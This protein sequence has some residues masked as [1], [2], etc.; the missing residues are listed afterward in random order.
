MKL[1]PQLI[2]GD[3]SAG[4]I[5]GVDSIIVPKN[6]VERAVNLVFDEVYGSA[7]VRKGSTA[8]GSQIENAN[9]DGLFN[10]IDSNNVNNKLLA[11]INGTTYYYDSGSWLPS[12]INDTAGLKT[13]FVTF[14]NEVAR[15]NGTDAVKTWDGTGGWSLSGSLLNTAAFPNGTVAAVYKDQVCVAGVAGD[16]D[17]IYISSIP[18]ATTGNIS[19]TSNNRKIGINPEDN[20]NITGLG[21]VS[22]LLIIFKDR[23]MY[24]WNNRSIEADEIISVGCSSHESIATGA[25]M[26]FFFN[27]QGIWATSGGQPV[28]ISRPVQDW[29]DGMSASYYDDVAGYSDG[30][31]YYCSIGSVTIGTDS[32]SNVVLRYTIE[33]KEWTVFSYA[34]QFSRFALYVTGGEEQILGGDTAGNV[35]QIESTATT[36]D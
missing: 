15:L 29:I 6:S 18:D 34:N 17:A 2:A 3:V 25:G 30:K 8:L 35:L 12:L 10:Y 20:S 28:R 16:P 19:W 24:R 22:D 33:T 26:L 14:L 7:K 23:A 5:T 32:Y 36:D 21:E 9:V 11:T 31:Y 27:Q 1:Q 4:V 13:R